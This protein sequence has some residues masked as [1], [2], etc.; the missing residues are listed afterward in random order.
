MGLLPDDKIK[1]LINKDFISLPRVKQVESF[2][3][4]LYEN[5]YRKV[6]LKDISEL[7]KDANIRSH[8]HQKK[9]RCGVY[10][11]KEFFELIIS[12]QSLKDF[13]LI[14]KKISDSEYEIMT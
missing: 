10:K 2:L 1:E 5:G 4:F 7:F 3:V 9:I 8:E 14:L 13:G 12:E 6:S 11:V